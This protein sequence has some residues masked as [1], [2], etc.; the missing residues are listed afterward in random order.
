MRDIFHIHWHITGICNLN[1]KHCYQELSRRELD[2]H[3]LRQIADKIKYFAQKEKV[4]CIITFTGGEPFLKKEVY[5]LAEYVDDFDCLA[6]INFISNGTLL[7]SPQINNLKK[8]STIYISLEG[9][10]EK[11]ND[12]IRGR[13]IHRQALNNLKLLSGKGYNIGVMTTLMRTNIF[14][15]ISNWGKY[16]EILDGLNIKEVILERF[17][18]AG[19]AKNLKEEVVVKNDL[20]KLYKVISKYFNID[21]SDLKKYPALKLTKTISTISNFSYKLF[22][23]RCTAGKYGVAILSDGEVYPCRR[24]DTSLGNILTQDLSSLLSDKNI[25]YSFKNT[26]YCLCYAMSKSEQ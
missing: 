6:K 24:W 11:I 9:V 23:A 5:E 10:D 26:D 13:G 19:R 18:P 17:I 8:L 20:F 16:I 2:I 22:G 1:C 3:Y 7:P 15:L 14:S 4:K 21:Y 12:E 25:F